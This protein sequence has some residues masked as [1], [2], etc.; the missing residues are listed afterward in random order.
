M[1]ERFFAS[2]LIDVAA[3][4]VTAAVGGLLAAERRRRVRRE[5]ELEKLR[6]MM[7]AESVKREAVAKALDKAVA[8][9]KAD[10]AYQ[11]GLHDRSRQR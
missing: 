8:R 4:L 10:L 7:E 9:F 11:R 6:T 1:P 2:N 3:G 5:A